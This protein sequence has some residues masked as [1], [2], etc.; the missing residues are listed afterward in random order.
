[1]EIQHPADVGSFKITMA[2]GREISLDAIHQ[3]PTYVGL[4]EG[5][6]QAQALS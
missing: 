1:M 5:Y 2:D 3:R 6:E 4:L